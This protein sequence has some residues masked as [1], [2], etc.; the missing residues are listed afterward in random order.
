MSTATEALFRGR[1]YR[2]MGEPVVA[3]TET[4]TSAARELHLASCRTLKKYGQDSDVLT[5]LTEAEVD[6]AWLRAVEEDTSIEVSGKEVPFSAE[7]AWCP[8]CLVKE[9]K[10]AKDGTYR[11]PGARSDKWR[12][13]V[14]LS[15][16]F[17]T[18][19][20]LGHCG[21]EVD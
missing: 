19:H 7:T 18:A 6:E 14:P 15:C 2:L 13:G 4:K 20:G 10:I 16:R 21:C 11:H 5:P 17:P 3:S 12:P 1:S 8:I 9:L